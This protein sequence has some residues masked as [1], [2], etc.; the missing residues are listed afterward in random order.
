LLL[1]ASIAYLNRI[2][3]S[4][5]LS[6]GKIPYRS[7]VADDHSRDLSICDCPSHRE[8]GQKSRDFLGAI[9]RCPQTLVRFQPTILRKRRLRYLLWAEMIAAAV[10]APRYGPHAH[11]LIRT[12][13][14]RD[15]LFHSCFGAENRRSRRER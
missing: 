5:D 6:G 15:V 14:N 9:V 8:K 13:L 11:E 10:V 3:Q 2:L 4:R 1:I 12:P 7:A